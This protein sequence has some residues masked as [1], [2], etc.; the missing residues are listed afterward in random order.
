MLLS[1]TDQAI[2]PG[3]SARSGGDSRGSAAARRSRKGYLLTLWG[4]G[5]TCPCAYC[6]HVLTFATI[7][8]DRVIPGNLG[9][10]YRRENVIPACRVC[11]ARRGDS[12]LWSFDPRLARRL[13]RR[14]YQVSV[15]R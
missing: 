2:R 14:G 7:E 10:S 11:N 6:G 13:V 3:K 4:D 5:E 1:A 15:A 12:T 9:G 8:A